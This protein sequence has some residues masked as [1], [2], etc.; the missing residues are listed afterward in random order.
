MW[1]HVEPADRPRFVSASK[2]LMMNPQLFRAAMIKAADAWQK[3]CEANL[4]AP[5]VNK[6]AWMGH[7][8]CCIQEGSPEHL[9]R[10]AWG[11]LDQ[12]A[13]DLANQMADEAID[14]WMK[15]NAQA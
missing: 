4:T 12:E 2:E 1:R 3:S 11:M 7:A 6:R 8:G 14:Y 15:K 13:Q 10:E 9:T 5:T